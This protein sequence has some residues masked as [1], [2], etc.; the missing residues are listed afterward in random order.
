MPRASAADAAQ[1]AQRVLDSATEL[2]SSRGFADV[3]LDD[4]AGA[5]G[6]TRGAVYHHYRNKAGLFGAVAARLQVRVA[7]AVVQAAQAAGADPGDQLRVGSHA[8]LDA[9]TS[10]T[11]VRILLIDA[12]SVVGWQEWRRLD[13]ENSAAHLRDALR[14]AGV[15]E[16][17]LDATTAQLSG[18]MNETALWIAQHANTD[19]AR[20][21]AH[22]A[23]NRLL[24]A[25]LS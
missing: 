22:S 12:P 18:A 20:A 3:S 11:A 4:V 7:D 9:I 17:L 1:T 5:A 13:A 16:E 6:V 23:L 14:A 24:A 15:D 19:V 25:Y 2:F 10:G 8:F 21:Q